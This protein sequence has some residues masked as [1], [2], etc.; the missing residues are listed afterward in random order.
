MKIQHNSTLLIVP[1]LFFLVGC[2]PSPNS[3]NSS[4]STSISINPTILKHIGSVGERYQS[5]N[6]EIGE[7]VGGEFW[8][9]YKL[10]DSLP[11]DKGGY[12]VS[13]KNTGFGCQ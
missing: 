7:V 12:D 11:S 5:Y 1:A 6:V 10:M 13:Q 3:D 2:N 4:D 8:K 9:P